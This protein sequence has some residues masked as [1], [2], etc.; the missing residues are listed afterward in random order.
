[1]YV[2]FFWVLPENLKQKLLSK[3]MK[4]RVYYAKC[5]NSSQAVKRN[6]KM[7]KLSDAISKFANQKEMTFSTLDTK[8]AR[9]VTS[10]EAMTTKHLFKSCITFW[11]LKNTRKF[12]SKKF[13]YFFFFSIIP[14]F[15]QS[16]VTNGPKF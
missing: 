3:K 8:T 13:S 1:M 7:E 11:V 12:S 15:C 4:I 10:M 16:F 14:T 5:N 9:Y 6:V 2:F